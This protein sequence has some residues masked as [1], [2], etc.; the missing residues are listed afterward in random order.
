[1]GC[2]SI[3]FLSPIIICQLYR[4]LSLIQGSWRSIRMAWLSRDLRDGWIELFVA[5]VATT[6]A[7]CKKLRF[8]A[9]LDPDSPLDSRLDPLPVKNHVKLVCK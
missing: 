8:W 6:L 1:V 5:M 7:V 4:P 9:E 2:C 3:Y